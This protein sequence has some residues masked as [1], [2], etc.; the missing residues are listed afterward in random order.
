MLFS[1]GQSLLLLLSAKSENKLRIE[2]F[3]EDEIMFFFI[4]FSSSVERTEYK[5]LQ[6]GLSWKSHAFYSYKI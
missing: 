6:I 5:F 1:F 4:C 2:I 3:C